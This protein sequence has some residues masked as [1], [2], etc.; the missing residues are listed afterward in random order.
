MDDFYTTTRTGYDT[1]KQNA[2]YGLQG[3]LPNPPNIINEMNQKTK[4]NLFYSLSRDDF[5]LI[6]Q[7]RNKK[8]NKK[9]T[10]NGL[11]EHTRPGMCY[12]WNVTIFYSCANT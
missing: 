5:T 8:F 10:I 9:K 12:L 3:I 11:Y 7:N 1:V 6:S 2:H 4:H